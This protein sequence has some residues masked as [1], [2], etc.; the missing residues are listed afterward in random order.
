MVGK[1]TRSA[2]RDGPLPP[3]PSDLAQAEEGS[4]FETRVGR[5]KSL[6]HPGREKIERGHRLWHYRSHAAQLEEEKGTMGLMPS[7]MY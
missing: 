2:Y 5:E 1:G 7:C 3:T 6:V 4:N